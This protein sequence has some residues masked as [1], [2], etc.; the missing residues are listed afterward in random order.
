M[1][2][3]TKRPRGLPAVFFKCC[4]HAFREG[5]RAM[6]NNAN[7]MTTPVTAR[8]RTK[9]GIETPMK[10]AIKCGAINDGLLS[11]SIGTSN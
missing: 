3:H 11:M 8:P 2:A 10:I 1:V 5:S 9:E 7:T 4:Q 6:H